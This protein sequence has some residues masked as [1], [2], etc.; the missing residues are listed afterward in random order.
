MIPVW[1]DFDFKINTTDTTEYSV[2]I[3]NEDKIYTGVAVP[4]PNSDAISVRLSE[5]A[6]NVVHSNIDIDFEDNTGYWMKDYCKDICLYDANDNIIYSGVFYN[7]YDYNKQYGIYDEGINII[8][9]PITTFTTGGYVLLT[10]FSG[11]D[12]IEDEITIIN[13]DTDEYYITDWMIQPKEAQ[14]LCFK[15]NNPGTYSVMTVNEGEIMQFK[16]VDKCTKYNL[17]YQN[18]AGGYDTLTIDGKRDKR[19]DNLTFEYYKSR[20]NNQNWNKP[21]M[22]KYEVDI[23]PKWELQTG[24]L[25]DE[26]SQ[27]MYNLFTSQRVW[28]EEIETNTIYPVYITNNSVEYKTFTNNGKKKINYAISVTSANTLI[29]L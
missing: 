7:S 12:A 19:T 1:R 9:N 26:Q 8:S 22:N 11:K 4:H 25:N 6:K 15:P 13:M 16:V 24:W 14:V 23:T 5:F 2:G 21:Q 27:K 28:L 10:F 20:G 3:L 17:H 18:A 29:K